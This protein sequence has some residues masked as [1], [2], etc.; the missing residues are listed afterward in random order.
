MILRT[1]RVRGERKE[2][3]SRSRLPDSSTSG[4]GWEGYQAQEKL[5]GDEK[6]ASLRNRAKQE[7]DARYLGPIYLEVFEYLPKADHPKAP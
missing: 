2:Q 5:G 1:L 3:R 4:A 6:L 7:N